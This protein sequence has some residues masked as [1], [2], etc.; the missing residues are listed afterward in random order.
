MAEDYTQPGLYQDANVF[1]GGEPGGQY[2]GYSGCIDTLQVLISPTKFQTPDWTSALKIDFSQKTSLTILYGNY[3]CGVCSMRDTLDTGDTGDSDHVFS[4]TDLLDLLDTDWEVSELP[5]P[6]TTWTTPPQQQQQQH[7]TDGET[8]RGY[9]D[10]SYTQVVDDTWL[11]NSKPIVVLDQT[12]ATTT[13]STTTKSTAAPTT[14][15]IKTT[16]EIRTEPTKKRIATTTKSTTRRTTTTPTTTPK[17]INVVTTK[18]IMTTTAMEYVRNEC[19]Q[20]QL[21]LDGTGW[22]ELTKKLMPQKEKYRTVLTLELS[23]RQRNSLIL[24][25]G[26]HRTGHYFAIALR[27]GFLEFR[28]VSNVC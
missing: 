6:M 11:I 22:L 26:D 24:W 19:V 12:T 10:N 21:S 16:T 3:Q 2:T 7:D 17:V 25:Q 28:Y 8:N 20:K 14:T 23:S 18:T 4:D 9:T 15:P 27:N 13:Q 5:R 1:L